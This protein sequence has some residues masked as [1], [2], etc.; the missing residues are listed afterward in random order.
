MYHPAICPVRVAP[1]CVAST[2]R[3]TAR[4]AHSEQADSANDPKNGR[5]FTS[6]SGRTIV[7]KISLRELYVLVTRK[8]RDID[9]VFPDRVLHQ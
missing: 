5:V 1:A 9:V 2:A 7:R 6:R 3:A 4:T 8:E